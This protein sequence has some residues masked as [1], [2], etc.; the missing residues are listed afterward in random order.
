[1]PGAKYTWEFK[2]GAWDGKAR[3]WR[4]DSEGSPG[5]ILKFP[6]GMVQKVHEAL[7]LNRYENVNYHDFRQIVP[8]QLNQTQVPLRPYQHDAIAAALGN[9]N[10]ALGWWPR[11]ILQVA[12]GGGKTEIAVAMYEMH[13]VPTFFLVHRKDLLIQAKERFEKYGHTVGQIGNSVFA[14]SPG[15]TVATIQTLHKVLKEPEDERHEVLMGKIAD[16][17]Q[18]FV[19]ECHLVASTLDKGNMFTETTNKF[20]RAYARWGLSATPFMRT[21]YDNLLLEGSSGSVLYKISNAKLIEMGYLTPPNVKMHPVPGK[22]VGVG[23]RNWHKIKELGIKLHLERNTLLAYEIAIGPS[24]VLA[25]VDTVE[26]GKFLQLL[27]RKNHDL[28]VPLLTG[29]DKAATRRQA[30]AA[31]RDGSVPA[32]IA[33]TIFDEGVDIPELQKVV[34][35]S[36]GKSQYKLL[37]RLGRGVRKAAGKKVVEIV[38]CADTHH[39][40]LRRHALERLKLYKQEGFRVNR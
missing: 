26:Q 11:G 5:V 12:T 4:D 25:L 40:T 35:C 29:L 31:L 39:P 19:D 36:G 22:L 16:T 14:P 13:P 38:D 28:D 3:L 17:R 15:L 8:T 20:T 21:Q 9:T 2:S 6:T 18:I 37:Q 30:V 34:L 32:I 1:V 23:N 33:T 24:P 27:L 7:H 10:G